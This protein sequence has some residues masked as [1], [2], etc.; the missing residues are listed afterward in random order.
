LDPLRWKYKIQVDVEETAKHARRKGFSVRLLEGQSRT[1]GEPYPLNQIEIKGGGFEFLNVDKLI[2]GPHVTQL[3]KK[4]SQKLDEIDRILNDIVVFAPK[5]TSRFGRE[6]R[7]PVQTIRRLRERKKAMEKLY[8]AAFSVLVQ[9]K[10]TDALSEGREYITSTE[11]NQVLEDVRREATRP[12]V[13]NLFGKR[14]EALHRFLKKYYPN[15]EKLRDV[16]DGKRLM[17]ILDHFEEYWK[18]E[19]WEE[20]SKSL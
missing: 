10:I 17:K 7:M 15:I 1:H 5:E 13:G 20:E 18:N 4:N 11:I 8:D 2:V 9:R 12:K 14:E 6:I 16:K 19:F 3:Y